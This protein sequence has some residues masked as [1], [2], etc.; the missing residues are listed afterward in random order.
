MTAVQ[1]GIPERGF[2]VPVRDGWQ[3]EFVRFVGLQWHCTCRDY[4]FAARRYE[5]VCEHIRRVQEVLMGKTEVLAPV[6]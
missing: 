1:V 2:R 6:R 5:F 4:A 3:S